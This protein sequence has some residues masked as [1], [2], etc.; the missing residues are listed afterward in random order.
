[1]HTRACTCVCFCVFVYVCVCLR[2]FVSV[3]V[4]G[5]YVCLCDDTR[6]SALLTRR[7]GGASPVRACV[8]IAQVLV[9]ITHDRAEYLRRALGS[10]IK[11]HPGAG[12]VPI[13]VSQVASL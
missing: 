5:A 8:W 10:V 1:M 4:C 9:M 12:S 13:I 2:V 6:P 7:C 3:C 11:H